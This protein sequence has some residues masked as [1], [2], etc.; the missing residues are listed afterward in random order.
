MLI[1]Q[2]LIVKGSNFQ[3]PFHLLLSQSLHQG[4]HYK[5]YV[6]IVASNCWL[7]MVIFNLNRM[8]QEVKFASLSTGLNKLCHLKSKFFYLK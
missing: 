2:M 5:E 1:R 4:C 6:K 7:E 8:I 3:V